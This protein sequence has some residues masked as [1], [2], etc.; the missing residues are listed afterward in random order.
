MAIPSKAPAR[1]ERAALPHALAV[2]LFVLGLMLYW[3]GVADRYAVFLYGH[4]GATPFDAVTSSRYWMS[5]LVAAGTVL[6]LYGG[7]GFV[8]GQLDAA[9]VVEYR[10]PRW[11]PVWLWCAAPAALGVMA[12]TMTANAPTLTLRLALATAL[13]TVAGLAPALAAGEWAA[14]RPLE[15]ALLALDGVGLV[16][17]LVLLRAVELPGRGLKVETGTAWLVAGTS[18]FAAVVWLGG[19]TLLRR[20]L[21]RP[22][23]DAAAILAA[24]AA[25]SYLVLPLAHHLLAT[26]RGFRYISAASNFF[27]LSPWLEAVALL[28]ALLIALGFGSLRRRLGFRQAR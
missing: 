3:F 16:L 23:G 5:G 7:F 20:G 13:A 27:A 9:G 24:G 15:L 18:L 21:R 22:G 4:L 10:A 26:P 19:T 28:T 25:W 8:A 11:Q 12:I 14:R 17:V 6:A 2:T 1:A